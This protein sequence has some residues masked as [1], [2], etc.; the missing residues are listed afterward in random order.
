[1]MIKE[2]LRTALAARK[3][4]PMESGPVPAAVLIPLFLKNGEY[5]VFFTKRTT[6]LTHH[7]G[8]ISF[9]GGVREPDDRDSAYTALRETW[10]EVGILPSDVEVV[11]ELDDC[12]S[13]H[14][15]LVTPVVG[16]FPSDYQLTVSDAEIERI[17]EVP[18]S[19]FSKPGVFRVE[20][21]QWQ[22]KRR[23][24][25]FYVHG[26]DEIWG[27]TARIMK[28]FLDVLNGE[29]HAPEEECSKPADF[30][31]SPHD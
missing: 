8:E 22:G 31:Y 11:G 17:I 14:N 18:L 3:R 25:Y 23:A 29:E 13:I 27:L 9:P 5:H 1:M 30:N 28:Q 19:H 21:W 6:H 26:E 24:M 7:S 16:F 15:Y 10:E 2:K 4:V 12:H 20:D